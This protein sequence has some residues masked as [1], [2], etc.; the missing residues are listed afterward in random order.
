MAS[1]ITRHGPQYS[2]LTPKAYT[3]VFIYTDIVVLILQAAGGALVDTAADLSTATTGT[4][5]IVTSLLFQVISLTAFSFLTG[6]NF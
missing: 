3:I 5:A 2:R 4:N 1:M 6:E